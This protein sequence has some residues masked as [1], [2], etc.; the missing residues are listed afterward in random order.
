MEF[1]EADL[2][3]VLRLLA[4]EHPCHF[5]PGEADG[6]QV[7]AERNHDLPRHAE[8]LRRVQTCTGLAG[9]VEAPDEALIPPEEYERRYLT[10]MLEKVGWVIKG[11]RGAAAQLNMPVSTLRSRMKKLGIQR[12]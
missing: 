6:I 2:R 9:P 5:A 12:P 4:Q 8:Q 3:D 11:P 7:F 10:R 1:R